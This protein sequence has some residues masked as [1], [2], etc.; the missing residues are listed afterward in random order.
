MLA[1]AADPTVQAIVRDPSVQVDVGCDLLTGDGWLDISD[2]VEPV[3]SVEHGSYRTIHRTCNIRVARTLDWGK[4]RVRLRMILTAPAGTFEV[5]L[6]VFLLSTP[7][8]EAGETPRTFEVEGYDLLELLDH[9]HGETFVAVQGTGYLANARGLVEAV[10]LPVSF[11]DE[12]ADRL[13]SVP[14]LVWPIDEQTTTLNVV[15][16]LLE[17]VGFR[18]LTVDPNGTARSEPYMPPSDRGVEWVYDAGSSD[19]T[20]GEQ[21]TAIFDFFDAP[22]R[23]VAVSDDPEADLA[24]VVLTNDTDGP[25]SIV[26]RG[27]TITAV[28][29]FEAADVAALTSQAVEEFAQL[30]KVAEEFTVTVSPNPLMGHMD[31]VRLIDPELGV[32]RKCLVRSWK[33][34]LAGGDMQLDLRAV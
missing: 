2:D 8:M 23:L 18:G 26:G 28:R 34:D 25:T 4:D 17:A 22:N 24:A 29:R 11:A 9:P 31:I 20:V 15:N 13:I 12:Q 6:G 16:G 30:S 1:E 3:G 32:D 7:Q 33:L 19:T 21:R 10:G 5:P 27:R 14:D